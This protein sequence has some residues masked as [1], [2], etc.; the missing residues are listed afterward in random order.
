M[1]IVKSQ[2]APAKGVKYK[3]KLEHTFNSRFKLPYETNKLAYV[4]THKYTP[5][6]KL[7]PNRYVETKGL[8]TG[9]DRTKHLHIKAQHPEVKVLF[10]FQD[11]D[12]KLSKKSQTSYADWCRAQGFKFLSAV[13]AQGHNCSTL[14][15]F[16]EGDEGPK[17]ISKPTSLPFWER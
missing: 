16:L 9:P 15:A 2:L 17:T 8:F 6:F 14:L 12:K 5:D 3:S 10:V 4:V 1:R 11:P 7:A 13:E